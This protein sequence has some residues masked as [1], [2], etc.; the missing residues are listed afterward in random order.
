MTKSGKRGF[1]LVN[2][3]TD[4]CRHVYWDNIA[5]YYSDLYKSDREMAVSL[6]NPNH[7]DDACLKVAQKICAENWE[8]T[9]DRKMRETMEKRIEE[10]KKKDAEEKAAAALIYAPYMPAGNY[11][12]TKPSVPIKQ[13]IVHNEDSLMAQRFRRLKREWKEDEKT[14]DS[15]TL[16]HGTRETNIDKFIRNGFILPMEQGMLGSG[17]YL[18]PLEKAVNYSGRSGMILKVRVMLGKC[19]ELRDVELIENANGY[20]SLHMSQGHYISVNKGYLKNDEWVIRNPD[21]I[22]IISFERNRNG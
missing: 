10:K 8:N 3:R 1:L 22:K 19:K 13:K 11:A 14:T 4:K 20:D 12:P 9:H 16:Y 17:I 18:G 6:G 15:I 5:E 2:G 7:S 21:Q